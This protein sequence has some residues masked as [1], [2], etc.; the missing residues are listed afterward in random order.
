VSTAQNIVE[1]VFWLFDRARS[2]FVTGA[3]FVVDGGMTR[4]MI[5]VE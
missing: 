2:S 4:K 3:N 1:I 5:Y